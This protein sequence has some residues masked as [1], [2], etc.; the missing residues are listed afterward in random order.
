[1]ELLRVKRDMVFNEVR[2]AV[3][4]EDPRAVERREQLGIEDECSR[5][6]L[7]EALVEVGEGKTPSDRVVLRAL[8]EE[9]RNWPM[10][11]DDNNAPRAPKGLSPYAKVTPTGVDPA[12]AARRAGLSDWDRAAELPQQEEEKSLGE[13]LPAWMGYGMLYGFSSIPIIIVVVVAIILF[14]NS[15]Q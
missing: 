9:M 1:M 11:N 4:I 13:R 14:L 12:V 2:L 8:T 7:A 6:E 15:L 10:I 5:D 3:M